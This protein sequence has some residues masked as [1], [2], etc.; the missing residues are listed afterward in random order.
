[1]NIFLLVLVL[2]GIIPVKLIIGGIPGAALKDIYE[3]TKWPWV[4]P[5]GWIGGPVGDALGA[6]LVSLLGRWLI[7]IIDADSRLWILF[8][9]LCVTQVGQLQ[10]ASSPPAALSYHKK[11]VPGLISGLVVYTIFLFMALFHPAQSV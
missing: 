11:L 4:N 7:H 6:V 5:Y 9:V 8:A 2:V 1:M 3:R 10:A